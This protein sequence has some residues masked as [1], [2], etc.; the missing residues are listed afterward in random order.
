M[1]DR[2]GST[3]SVLESQLAEILGEMKA[4][5]SELTLQGARVAQLEGEQAATPTLAPAKL[6]T[7]RQRAQMLAGCAPHQF[8]EKRLR[9]KQTVLGVE[10]PPWQDEEEELAMEAATPAT[11]TDELLKLALVGLL[12]KERRGKPKIVGISEEGSDGSE[13][14]GLGSVM[15]ARSTMALER[16]HKAMLEHPGAFADRMENLAAAVDGGSVSSSV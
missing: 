2:G 1:V 9:A 13:G 7:A 12:K 8:G 3:T 4:M 10:A 11:S 5:R 16:L 14:D 15:G 6:A